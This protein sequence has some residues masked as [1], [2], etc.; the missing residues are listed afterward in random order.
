MDVF[1]VSLGLVFLAEMGD[2]TQLVA[3]TLAGR[4][5]PW[6]VLAGITVATGVSH[7]LSVALGGIAGHFLSGPWV[8][9]LAGISFV[10]FG[11][12]TLRGDSDDDD[13][14]RKS[15]T[16]FLAV[17]WTFLIAEMGDKTMLTTATVTAQNLTHLFPVWLGSTLGMVLADGI[18]IAIGAW[19]GTR[20]PEKPVRWVCASVFLLF[21]AWSTWQGVVKLPAWSWAMGAAILAVGMLALFRPFRRTVEP[22]EI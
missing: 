18:A 13:G 19:A 20:L 2:K 11:L 9:Y 6:I 16:P 7:V 10:L 17:F 3:L 5:N 4:Y 12:W 8:T 15:A 21:G 14:I 22:D 1:V